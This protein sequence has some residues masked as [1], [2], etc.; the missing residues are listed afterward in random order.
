MSAIRYPVAPDAETAL[1]APLGRAEREREA[2]A[3]AGR[4]VVF[5]AEAVGAPFETREAALDAYPGR[6]DDDRPGRSASVAPEDRFCQLREEI[7]P[8]GGRR[9]AVRPTEPAYADGRRWPK[10][11]GKATPTRWRL[12]VS[13]WR[14]QPAA[15]LAQARK[16]R[17]SAEAAALSAAEMR[18]MTAQPLRPV[19]PQQP[20]DIG[21]FETPA[22]EA[23][24]IQIPDE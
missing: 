9:R 5:Q 18:K 19:R 13:Y 23:P 6:L 8:T 21:L 12:A 2:E 24:H 1:A 4:P 7:A 22:P 20:L 3:I 16:A 15:E 10:S 17:R 14:I 11:A